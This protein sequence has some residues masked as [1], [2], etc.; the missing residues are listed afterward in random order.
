MGC[1]PPWEMINSLVLGYGEVANATETDIQDQN[2]GV[3]RGLRGQDAVASYGEYLPEGVEQS[4]AVRKGTGLADGPDEDHGAS[5]PGLLRIAGGPG[6]EHPDLLYARAIVVPQVRRESEPRKDKSADQ[7]R[8]D[9]GK[10]AV[11]GGGRAGDT[12]RPLSCAQGDAGDN[13][14]Y[15]DEGRGAREASD[16]GPRGPT[17]DDQRQRSERPGDPTRQRVLGR[18]G[19]VSDAPGHDGRSPEV[20]GSQGREQN[21]PIYG[22]RDKLGRKELREI[23]ESTHD[24]PHIAEILRTASVFTRLPLGAAQG[25]DGSFEC[26]NDDTIPGNRG[27][28]H[29][30]GDLALPPKLPRCVP[31]RAYPAL[32]CGNFHFAIVNDWSE[33]RR[34]KDHLDSLSRMVKVETITISDSSFILTEAMP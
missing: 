27:F 19:F 32:D 20:S 1:P 28:G 30:A 33:V 13:V 9:Q 24:T 16:E 26:R 31:I 4:M 10:L 3:D 22:R 11:G 18:N 8:E 14:L 25:I 15:G 6:N 29:S 5:C 7:T 21:G 23:A 2:G 34:Y 12:L 17:G